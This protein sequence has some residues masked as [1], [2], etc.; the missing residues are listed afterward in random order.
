VALL[1]RS[2]WV[3]RA[4]RLAIAAWQALSAAIV[5]AVV[6]AGL[7]LAIPTAKLTGDAAALLK[8]CAMAL[9]LQYANWAAH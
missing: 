6:L 2:R 7:V 1:R 5:L 9:R 8:A 3:D 4:P